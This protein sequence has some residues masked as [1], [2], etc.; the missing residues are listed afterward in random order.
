MAVYET[1]GC[2]TYISQLCIM[3]L[4]E[5]FKCLK[6]VF[7]CNSLNP[8]LIPCL[9]IYLLSYHD[10]QAYHD[11]LCWTEKNELVAAGKGVYSYYSSLLVPRDRI[12]KDIKKEPLQAPF[13]TIVWKKDGF[14]KNLLHY[15]WHWMLLNLHVGSTDA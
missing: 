11:K 2:C 10:I 6:L 9:G 1:T 15:L 13:L 5:E 7:T 12:R 4:A 14:L 8:A 3:W